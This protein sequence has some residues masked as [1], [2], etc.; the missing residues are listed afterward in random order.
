MKLK[1]IIYVIVSFICLLLIFYLYLLYSS[2]KAGNITILGVN[3]SVVI[4]NKGKENC[5]LISYPIGTGNHTI[6][7][8]PNNSTLLQI[9]TKEYVVSNESI[10][11]YVLPGGSS[12]YFYLNKIEEIPKNINTVDSIS[13]ENNNGKS[14]YSNNNLFVYI[15]PENS[16]LQIDSKSIAVSNNGI[17]SFNLTSQKDID[18]YIQSDGYIPEKYSIVIKKNYLVYNTVELYKSPI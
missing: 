5:P 16:Q 7:I 1:Y 18:I 13:D 10:V 3:C 9:I 12:P 15:T 8:K 17:Y 6:T 11:Y 4:D 2:L 14:S